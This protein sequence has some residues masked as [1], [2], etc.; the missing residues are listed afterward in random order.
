MIELDL[1]KYKAQRQIQK[2]KKVLHSNIKRVLENKGMY[3]SLNGG[4][5]NNYKRY[6]S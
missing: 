6:Y 5:K 4:R 2:K 1:Q 3:F